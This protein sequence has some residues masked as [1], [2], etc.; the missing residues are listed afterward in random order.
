[1]RGV[2]HVWNQHFSHHFYPNVQYKR[3]W[4]PKL[5]PNRNNMKLVSSTVLLVMNV[6]TLTIQ[7]KFIW[8]ALERMSRRFPSS[9][10]T[11]MQNIQEEPD[12]FTLPWMPKVIKVDNLLNL[13]ALTW[14]GLKLIASDRFSNGFW[15]P[16][17]PPKYSSHSNERSAIFL[18]TF[19]CT[20]WCE[21]NC[22]NNQA[23]PESK[24]VEFIF[25]GWG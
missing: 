24:L 3:L 22:D 11:R 9:W 20:Q 17:Q 1:M 7:V 16:H 5:N 12:F 6:S 15:Q 2:E 19:E 18:K 8:S 10:N 23:I 4:K 14:V 21:I 25:Q 13:Q